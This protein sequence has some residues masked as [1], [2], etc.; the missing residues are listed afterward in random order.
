MRGFVQNAR[1]GTNFFVINNE[2]RFPIIKYFANRPLNSSFFNNFQI[3]GFADAGSAWSGLTP[4]D[5]SNA[6]NTETVQN[7]PVTVIIDKNRSSVVLGYGFG[8][9]TKIFGYFL[10]LDWAWGIDNNIILPRIFYL[11][12]NLDF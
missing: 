1:N 6:Y 2:I 5:P 7:G 9:R 8:V 11:S 4:K 3:V 12:L 10:R